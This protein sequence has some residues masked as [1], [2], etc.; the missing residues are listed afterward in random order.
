M[1]RRRFVAGVA[2]AL[3]WFA[4][5]SQFRPRSGSGTEGTRYELEAY[6]V[7]VDG[8]RAASVARPGDLSEEA[9]DVLLA[10]LDGEKA[11]TYGR[12]FFGY[13][14]LVEYRGLFYRVTVEETG[15]ETHERPVLRAEVV[16]SEAAEQNAVHWS[17]YSGDDDIAVKDAASKAERRS[18]G[19]GDEGGTDGTPDD[20]TSDFRV[21]RDRDPEVS[22]LLPEPEHEYVEYDGSVLRLSVERRRVTET[23]YT[24]ATEQVAD[25]ASELRELLR[26]EVVDVWLDSSDLS[27]R[28]RTVFEE[29]RSGRYAETGGLTDAYRGLLE[30][31]FGSPLPAETTGERVGYDGRVHK[32][33]V[34]VS[35]R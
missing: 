28:Q 8:L 1:D 7:G 24:Y 35:D 13:V 11:R 12:S 29:A 9:F 2:G 4:G 3:P 19:T 22:D 31:V 6:P 23:E 25:S 20:G 34:R 30:R 14:H 18:N 15:R 33:H 21:L 10:A 5:C 32:V 17:A 26:E 27:A 16:E